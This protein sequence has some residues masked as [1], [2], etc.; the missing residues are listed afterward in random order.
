MLEARK[1]SAFEALFGAYTVRALRGAFHAVH[2]AGRAHLERRD[3]RASFL[4]LG[5]HS[6]WWDALLPLF[7]SRNVFGLDSYAMMEEKQL[8][9]FPFFRRIGVFSIK[10][11]NPKDVSRSLHYARSLLATP[12]TALWMYPQGALLPAHTRP[13]RFQRGVA[14]L[15]GNTDGVLLIPFAL[16]YAFRHE[17]NP[18]VFIS[19]G[20]G[21][22]AAAHADGD[23]VVQLAEARVTALLDGILA[24]LESGDL[25]AYETV[26]RGRRWSAAMPHDEDGR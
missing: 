8:A 20:A 18:E 5:N 23:A 25:R 3:P 6:S 16:H 11:E 24:D 15:A 19:I 4:L 10:R 12:G 17:R 9:R 22:P 21:I 7:L 26:L 14:R 1:S 13:L 2:L